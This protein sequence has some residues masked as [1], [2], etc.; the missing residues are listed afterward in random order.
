MCYH[1][2]LGK[3]KVALEKKFNA[4]AGEDVQLPVFHLGAFG[5]RPTMPVLRAD[6]RAAFSKM[7]WG[8]IP[9]WSNEETL[10]FNTAN[11]AIEGI[12]GKASYRKPIASQR[13]LVP[14]DGFFEWRHEGGIKYPYFIHLPGEELFAFAGI[15]DEWI[16]KE[17]GEVIESYSILTKEANPFMAKIHNVKKRMPI[18]VGEEDYDEYLHETDTKGLVDKLQNHWNQPELVGHTISKSFQR[19]APGEEQ[20]EAFEYPELALLDA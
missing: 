17:T 14:A 20:R 8:L 1:Y 2:S 6:Q 13:C 16:N 12:T 18:L 5:G 19:M 7:R 10:K 3:S 4:T 11:A 9:H 15:F